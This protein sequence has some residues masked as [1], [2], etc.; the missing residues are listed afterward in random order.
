[1]N[2]GRL[3]G[4]MTTGLEEL[5]DRKPD[6]TG[7]CWGQP[8][9]VNLTWKKNK[10]WQVLFQPDPLP[11]LAPG[12][13]RCYPWSEQTSTADSRVNIK[14]MNQHRS[15]NV[16]FYLRPPSVIQVRCSQDGQE[17]I[18]ALTA[19]Q[20][21]PIQLFTEQHL[22]APQVCCFTVSPHFWTRA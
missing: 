11:S 19:H 21:G 15:E 10:Q 12:W 16:I 13:T 17:E 1:M 18:R 9:W 20:H 7:Q 3:V 22:N 14:L 8:F 5:R 4:L 2:R 6:K